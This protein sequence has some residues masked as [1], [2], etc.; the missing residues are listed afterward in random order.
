MKKDPTQM[1]DL[2]LAQTV[3][4]FPT[5]RYLIDSYGFNFITLV[6][7]AAT[8]LI[9]MYTGELWWVWVG[10]FWLVVWL[11]GRWIDKVN[12]EPYL[13]EFVLRY[14]DLD[15]IYAR[16]SRAKHELRSTNGPDFIVLFEDTGSRPGWKYCYKF[17]VFKNQNRV[18]GHK[19]FM[20]MDPDKFAGIDQGLMELDE[21]QRQK[22]IAVLENGSELRIRK[23]DCVRGKDGFPL[24]LSVV[25]REP[26]SRT[27]T[28]AN[29]QWNT[30]A[31]SNPAVQ[32]VKL[33]L[34][35]G[36]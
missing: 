21:A 6:E 24:T 32:L 2:E 28:Y 26:L 35:V 19:A 13:A 3:A 11:I 25:K 30:G 9:M 1:T 23:Y 14:P 29:T 7:I 22:M 16:V 17:T 20:S 18:T 10:L 31:E 12:K 36:I 34:E 15:E 4:S 27:V 8:V 5:T 33:I